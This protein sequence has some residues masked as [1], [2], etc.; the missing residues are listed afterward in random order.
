M[1]R[2]FDRKLFQLPHFPCALRG[3]RARPLAPFRDRFLVSCIYPLTSRLLFC[4]YLFF[5]SA[6]PLPSRPTLSTPGLEVSRVSTTLKTRRKIRWADFSNLSSLPS[7]ESIILYL[8]CGVSFLCELIFLLL[9][10]QLES[11]VADSPSL[12]FS[13]SLRNRRLRQRYVLSHLI[14]STPF[15]FEY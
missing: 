8:C 3:S 6:T 1:P 14:L 7:P 11:G 10:D 5:T 4:T 2:K 12:F 13:L 9:I 15:D